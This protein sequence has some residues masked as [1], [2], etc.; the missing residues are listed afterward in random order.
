MIRLG[1]LL[2]TRLSMFFWTLKYAL[3]YLLLNFQSARTI[4]KN[5]I[6]LLLGIILA[7]P[8]LS[9][10]SW[11]SLMVNILSIFSFLQLIQDKIQM[12]KEKELM[13]QRVKNEIMNEVNEIVE[14]FKTI[15]VSPVNPPNASSVEGIVYGVNDYEYFDSQRYMYVL[16][17]SDLLLDLQSVDRRLRYYLRYMIFSELKTKYR[18]K[19]I[20]EYVDFRK[21]D[22]A[23]SIEESLIKQI[24]YRVEIG[25]ICKDDSYVKRKVKMDKYIAMEFGDKIQQSKIN[26]IIADKERAEKLKDVLTQGIVKGLISERGLES[27]TRNQNKLLVVIK[28]GEGTSQKGW[29]KAEGAPFAKVLRKNRFE[30]PYYQDD[31]AFIRDLSANPIEGD[32]ESY[33]SKL[34]KDLEVDFSELKR[35]YKSREIIQEGPYYEILA[36]VADK[37]NFAWRLSRKRSFNSFISRV[38]LNEVLESNFSQDFI[39]ANFFKIKGII[40]NISWFSLIKNEKLKSLIEVNIKKINKELSFNNIKL[41]TLFDLVSLNSTGVDFLETAIH[42]LVKKRNISAKKA[43][44]NDKE[45]VAVIRKQIKSLIKEAENFTSIIKDLE[46]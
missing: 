28:Y 4:Y 9:G 32:L 29:P 34:I 36:F 26:K 5:Y 35:K 44:T 41:E 39:R 37:Q 3:D 21:F 13:R 23:N 31:F 22:V 14:F 1:V 12:E 20:D 2:K 10:I 27:I 15:G 46:K 17:L 42:K 11:L 18:Q 45:K 30:K 8:W 43:R 40:E 33:I 6:F 19:Y 16:R 7:A 25:E 38:L 24:A